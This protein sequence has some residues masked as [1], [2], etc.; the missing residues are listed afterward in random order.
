LPFTVVLSSSKPWLDAWRGA[1][2]CAAAAV[3]SPAATTAAE[4]AESGA[5]GLRRKPQLRYT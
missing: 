2:L 5:S 4:W 1:S 3:A